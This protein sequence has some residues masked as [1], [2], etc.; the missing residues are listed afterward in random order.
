MRRLYLES[1]GIP[2]V[3]GAQ[4]AT[5]DLKTGDKITVD[6]RKGLIYEGEVKISDS[7]RQRSKHL[8]L[9]LLLCDCDEDYC[10]P[11]RTQLAEKVAMEDVDG[12]RTIESG[13]YYH[14]GYWLSIQRRDQGLSSGGIHHQT[15]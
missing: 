11:G 1:L 10:E 5:Q 3:V 7:R 12:A 15:C 9:I 4:T 8:L 13:I 14:G 6:G 2:C